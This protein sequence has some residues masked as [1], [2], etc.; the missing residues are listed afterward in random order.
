MRKYRDINCYKCHKVIGEL[1]LEGVHDSPLGA[2]PLCRSK[3]DYRKAAHVMTKGY[4]CKSCAR[5]IFPEG[6]AY[7]IKC[8][9]LVCQTCGDVDGSTYSR[10]ELA[11]QKIKEWN[12][13]SVRA[14]YKLIEIKI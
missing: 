3:F 5:K 7:R 13:K 2:I 14:Y 10:K 6:Y 8:G 1:L 4:L 12:S 11:Q 9:D